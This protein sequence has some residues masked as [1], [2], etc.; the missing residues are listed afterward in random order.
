M[1]MSEFLLKTAV[2]LFGVLLGTIFFSGLWLTVRTAVS[3]EGS[4]IWLLISRVLRTAL[5][6]SGFYLVSGTGWQSMLVCLVGFIAS[7]PLVT[8]FLI[9]NGSTRKEVGNGA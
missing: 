6:L 5:V 1:M 3:T 4:V 2:F 7:R 9:P 8:R